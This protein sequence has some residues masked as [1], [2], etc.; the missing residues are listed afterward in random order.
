MEETP[1]QR[2]IQD[3]ITDGLGYVPKL[4]E[5]DLQRYE[6]DIKYN[7][8]PED[9]E[10]DLQMH[11]GSMEARTARDYFTRNILLDNIFALDGMKGELQK[12]GL[13]YRLETSIQV[14]CALSN[15]YHRK[16]AKDPRVREPEKAEFFVVRG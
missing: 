10:L 14:V 11:L 16:G 1:I 15:W 5:R 13:E 6:Q 3:R 7:I 4:T 12:Y 9:T 2:L 8:R